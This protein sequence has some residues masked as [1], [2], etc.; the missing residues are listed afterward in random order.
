MDIQFGSILYQLV[1]ILILVLPIVL[2]VWLIRSSSRRT[3]QLDRI[4]AELIELNKS[5]DQKDA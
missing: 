4:E 2:I 1:T 5:R 3:K